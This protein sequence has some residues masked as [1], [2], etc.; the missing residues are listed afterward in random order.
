[1][2]Y[3]DIA[4]N[5]LNKLLADAYG[6]AVSAGELPEGAVI[7][8]PALS[9][10][11]AN[12]D[13]SS[14]FG[15]A[16]AGAFKMPP[17]NIATLL[18]SHIDL[19]NSLFVS[20][21]VAGAGYINFRY[22]QNWYEGVL[23]AIA[24]EGDNFGKTVRER[25]ER[26]MVE[27]VSANPT[28]PMTIGNARGGVLG[29]TLASIL[30][31]AGYDV[32]RE[33]YL[34]DAGNQ[35]SVLGKSLEARFLQALGQDIEFPEDGY[36]GDYIKDFAASY[37]ADFGDNL[38]TLSTEER[39]KALASYVLPKNVAA[40]E[41]DL[42]RYGVRFD[43]WY[44][45]SELHNSGYVDETIALLTKNGYTYEKDDALWLE[46]TKFG[47]E[48]DEVMRKSNGFYTYYAT[49]IAYH[50]DKLE[51]RG[52]DLVIDALGADHHGHTVRFRAG[53]EALGLNPNRLQF[54][55]FQ[56]V[57]LVRDGE[58]VRM[59]KR[60]GKSITLS[61]LLDEIPLDAARFFFGMR[62][63]D[64]H[65]EFDLGL[66]VKASSDN[67]VY[68]VQYA[69]ARICTM[70]AVL[71]EMGVSIDTEGDYSLLTHETEVDLIRHIAMLPEEILLAAKD[72]DTSRINR[73]LVELATRYH[74]FY[75]KCRVKD[76]EPALRQ[77]RTM[78][79][80]ATRQTLQNGCRLLGITAP[81]K[82]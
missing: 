23:R 50:R 6:I 61:D 49:D 80:V 4:K 35:I 82:M 10:D 45:E 34:N 27:F 7:P 37:I 72:Y 5:Q 66:A 31:A 57:R 79:A 60:T 33:F 46:S 55:L 69:H 40:M 59:S 9:K 70:I 29:D 20:A 54:L 64:V 38:L 44:A 36:H 75:D 77:A 68:Y 73:Y 22:A 39:Q 53:V 16:N 74:R 13:L 17:R 58:V 28:G 26:V 12:G 51:K 32:W 78:L 62:N 2:N 56:L 41:N 8:P 18:H 15:L 14:T 76:A 63:P 24:A 3:L 52:F 19:E 71:E 48:K 1:M 21:E 11:V 25:P 65:L 30:E 67:P 43:R 47:L 42:A 81:V